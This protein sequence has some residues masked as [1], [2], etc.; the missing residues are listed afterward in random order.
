MKVS[1]ILPIFNGEETLIK[2]LDSLVNQSFQDF[3][4]I[5]CIDGSKDGSLQILE[6]YR[7]KLKK[8]LIL[9]N[10]LNIGLGPTMNRLV[11][12][13]QGDY[14]AV[15]E[16]D[17]Y[18][19]KDRLKLQ[20]ELL[21]ANENI[22]LVS[23]IAE[24]WNGEKVSALFPGI[25]VSK[26]QYPKGKEMFLL[27]YRKQLKVV[28]SCMMF[29]KEVHINNGLY[30]TKHHP[31]ISVDWTYILR[32]LLISEIYG[33]PEILVRIDRREDR[34]SIT[35]NKEKQF[36]A[37]RE[38]LRSFKYEYPEI[39][40]KQDY[41]FALNTQKLMEVSQFYGISFYL[42]CLGLIFLNPKEV[43]FRKFMF[44]RINHKIKI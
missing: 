12:N 24:F 18:Y 8:L 35:T 2:T 10:N 22:G 30:F 36:L 11:A 28:N 40:A 17:D 41:N 3:E 44:N 15:A 39:I 25:L 1:V 33:I 14:I 21:D 26:K 42:K 5:A 32:F 38:L 4:L 23:G 37:T 16:Q 29:R 6:K 43:R 7:S 31:N 9:V 20:V 27:N 13:T 19:Y 34:N